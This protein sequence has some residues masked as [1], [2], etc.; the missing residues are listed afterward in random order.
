MSLTIIIVILIVFIIIFFIILL[1][2][3]LKKRVLLSRAEDEILKGENKIA[4]KKLLEVLQEDP[5][6]WEAIKNLS[7]LYLKNKSYHQALK[8]LEKALSVPNV[9]SNWNQSE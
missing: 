7:L 1:F 5:E 2:R 9:L 4:E 6:N 8:Y 3:S